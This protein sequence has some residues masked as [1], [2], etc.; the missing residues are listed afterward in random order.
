M[1]FSLVLCACNNNDGGDLYKI[2]PIAEELETEYGVI[3]W[4]SLT[5]E[6]RKQYPRASFIIRSAEDFPEQNLMNLEEIKAM[7]INFNQYTLLLS[8]NLIPGVVKGHRYV[9]QKNLQEGVFILSMSF[10][11]RPILTENF[12]EADTKEGMDEED[13][14]TYYCTALL[15]NKIPSNAEVEFWRSII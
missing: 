2:Y 8:Y 6:E 1:L 5:P 11:T 7:H 9:W 13:I 15:V 3:D 12:E 14:V 4:P 10:S